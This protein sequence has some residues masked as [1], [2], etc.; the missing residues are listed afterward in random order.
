MTN[1]CIWDWDF[2]ILD[3]TFEIGLNFWD[4]DMENLVLKLVTETET[5]LPWS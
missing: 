4:R 5:T 3:E 1:F 2:R